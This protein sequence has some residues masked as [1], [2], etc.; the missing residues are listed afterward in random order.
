MKRLRPPSHHPLLRWMVAISMLFPLSAFACSGITHGPFVLESGPMNPP[1]DATVTTTW[2]IDI[3]NNNDVCDERVLVESITA[4][5]ND[6]RNKDL[7]EDK[8]SGLTKFEGFKLSP[9]GV[10]KTLI[11]EEMEDEKC[12]GCARPPLSVY[13]DIT[14]GEDPL[15]CDFKGFQKTLTIRDD[16][17]YCFTCCDSADEAPAEPP[18]PYNPT[19]TV[20]AESSSSSGSGTIYGW[21]SRPVLNQVV[22]QV[23][24]V[25]AKK[26]GS[27]VPDA[28]DNADSYDEHQDS[29]DGAVQMPS[30]RGCYVFHD[31]PFG[32]Y[33]I[34]ATG[35][36]APFNAE[37]TTVNSTTPV[38][39]NLCDGGTCPS[40]PE[41]AP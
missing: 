36:G 1:P 35:D 9:N 15:G 20:D 2:R 14:T 34:R 3:S 32:K 38:E 19:L 5:I 12:P 21:I 27:C 41:C 23:A 39:I 30:A 29:M 40:N 7:A 8:R 28:I 17:L 22:G 4:A 24:K 10:L 11:N 6:Y 33:D 37:L 25:S 18:T 16:G 13:F 26:H 31:V